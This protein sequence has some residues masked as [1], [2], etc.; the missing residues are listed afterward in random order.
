[1]LEYVVRTFD[2]DE[3]Y[4]FGQEHGAL[5]QRPI[6]EDGVYHSV[7]FPGLWLD[8]GVLLEGDTRRLRAVVEKGC[9]AL[10]HETFVSRLDAA[11]QSS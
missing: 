2:P 11:R 3:I 7:E 1:M 4:W 6:G 8:A 10:D 9:V 5:V